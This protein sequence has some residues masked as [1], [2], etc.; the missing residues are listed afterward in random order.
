MLNYKEIEK[1]R[2]I[3]ILQYESEEGYRID[4][5]TKRSKL[6]GTMEEAKEL[7]DFYHS[8]EKWNIEEG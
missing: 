8:P 4:L 7:I 6:V 3:P 1:Y 2:D 5:G